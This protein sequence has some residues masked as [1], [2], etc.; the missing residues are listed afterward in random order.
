[1][2]TRQNQRRKDEEKPE[3]RAIDRLAQQR[4][5]QLATDK[6]A[7]DDAEAA[8]KAAKPAAQQASA[9]KDGKKKVLA[10]NDADATARLPESPRVGDPQRVGGTRVVTQD[11]N[12]E[13]DERRFVRDRDEWNRQKRIQRLEELDRDWRK[14]QS[15]SGF[16]KARFT[17]TFN[18]RRAKTVGSW[19]SRR[20]SETTRSPY[21]TEIDRLLNGDGSP[22]R[23]GVATSSTSREGNVTPDWMPQD[24]S[25]DAKQRFGAA[26]FFGRDNRGRSSRYAGGYLSAEFRENFIN[27]RMEG[28]NPG[29][30][31]YDAMRRKAEGAWGQ[32]VKQYDRQFMQFGQEKL[33]EQSRLDFQQRRETMLKQQ[34]EARQRQAEEQKK[35][36]G[37]RQRRLEAR[38]V[39]GYDPNARPENSALTNRELEQAAAEAVRNSAARTGVEA[40]IVIGSGKNAIAAVGGS[41]GRS[42]TWVTKNDGNAQQFLTSK[43]GLELYGRGAIVDRTSPAKRGPQVG[44]YTG[45]TEMNVARR[46][47]DAT[48]AKMARTDE[49]WKG[50]GR[51]DAGTFE[52]VTGMKREE[53]RMSSGGRYAGGGTIVFGDQKTFD[54]AVAQNQKR[55]RGVA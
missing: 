21:A 36:V 16:G 27:S 3:G 49:A 40:R 12:E 47:Q 45:G 39:Q 10:Q 9:D 52:L 30:A 2:A 7:Q 17:T 5:K 32:A 50:I 23:R 55:L 18:G 43:H 26:D 11:R 46:E 29:D 31:G 15:K 28:L 19:Q 8:K 34:E 25:K 37:D 22:G 44:D 42:T 33:R 38:G 53:S 14:Q 1:M 54:A 24:T 20:T 4:G 6:K 35:A 51:Q 13:K 41:N 48:V